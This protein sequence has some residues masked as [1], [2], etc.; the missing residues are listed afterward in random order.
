LHGRD[1]PVGQQDGSAVDRVAFDGNDTP[2]CDR[3]AASGHATAL[4]VDLPT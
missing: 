2:A 3:D 1:L 4:S